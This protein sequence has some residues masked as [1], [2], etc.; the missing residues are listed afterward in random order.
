MTTENR[1]LGA[2][3]AADL[4]KSMATAGGWI[5]SRDTMLS[6]VASLSFYPEV[7]AYLWVALAVLVLPYF[8]M[9]AF[10]L[11]AAW[12]RPITRLACRALLAS[13]VLWAFLAYLSK[14]IDSANVTGIFILNSLTSVAMSAI[15]AS[16]INTAQAKEAQYQEGRA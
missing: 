3:L 15:L 14:N 16:S 10:G 11:W 12:H 1:L 6:R 13:G 4:I 7:L 2:L 8:C 5:L 9:Q